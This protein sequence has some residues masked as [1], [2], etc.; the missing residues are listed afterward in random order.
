MAMV[1]L[2]AAASLVLAAGLGPITGRA[3]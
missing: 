2:A 1:G 3:W